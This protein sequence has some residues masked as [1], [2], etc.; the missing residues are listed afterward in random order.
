MLA[1]PFVSPIVV[2]SGGA[3]VRNWNLVS[4]QGNASVRANT[5]HLPG[6][7]STL[8]ISHQTVGSGGNKRDR[9]LARMES[10]QV[11][12]GV[13]DTSKPPIVLYVVADF[14]SGC[15]AALALDLWRQFTGMLLGSSGNAAYPAVDTLFYTPWKSGQS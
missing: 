11:T 5:A 10:L 2:T 8:K 9:H 4:I 7:P 1:D 13:E 12:G 14:P 6:T 15:D 3:S